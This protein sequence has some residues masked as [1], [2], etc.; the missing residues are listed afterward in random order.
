MKAKKTS[1]N[2]EKASRSNSIGKSQLYKLLWDVK[3]G[4][5]KE[6]S[7]KAPKNSMGPIWRGFLHPSKACF[8]LEYTHGVSPISLIKLFPEPLVSHT[9]PCKDNNK[10]VIYKHSL[11]FSF[12]AFWNGLAYRVILQPFYIKIRWS[13]KEVY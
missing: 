12:P 7:G 9:G 5:K 6:N 3:C 8:C 11:C 2:M 1:E 4:I 13:L 10:F